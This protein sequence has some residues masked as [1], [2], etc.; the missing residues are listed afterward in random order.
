VHVHPLIHNELSR[1][2]GLELQASAGSRRKRDAEGSLGPIV[3]AAACGDSHAWDLL[4]GN[5]SPVLR[6]VVLGYR[7]RPA[8]VE[9][10]LQAT[11]EAALTHVA[12]LRDP[13]AFCGW[14]CVI[15][16]R[17]ALRTLRLGQREPALG[18]ESLPVAIVES[19]PESSLV[20][21]ER[22]R[23]VSSAIERLPRRQRELIVT[24]LRDTGSSY[25]DVSRKLGV[26]VGSIG[27]TRIRALARLRRDRELV[28]WESRSPESVASSTAR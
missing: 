6:R 22:D 18:D 10:V 28:S 4:V 20:E 13:D 14:L 19:T 9:D 26:P 12:D 23:I 15:A 16:R 21:K 1:Q 27:P 24:L 11:W 25:E 17:E 3:R 7:L 2:R 8:D 5:L